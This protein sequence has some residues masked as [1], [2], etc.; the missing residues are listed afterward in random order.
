MKRKKLIRTAAGILA[1]AAVL[2]MGASSISSAPTDATVQS[3]EDQLQEIA[4]K[5]QQALNELGSIDSAGPC[6]S[7][8]L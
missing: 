6:I 8:S 4:W 1:S 2:L 7:P 5:K 3:Y